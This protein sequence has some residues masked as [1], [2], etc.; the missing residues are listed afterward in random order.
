MAT[1]RFAHLGLA[2]ADLAAARADLERALGVTFEPTEHV[3]SQAVDVAFCDAAGL[4]LVAAT[5][6]RNPAIP[7]LPH[8]IASHLAKHGPGP[9]HVAYAVADLDAAI[10]EARARGV[11]TLTPEPQVGAGGHRVVF[12]HPADCHD[13]LVELCEDPDVR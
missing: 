5:S 13:L 4:E 12:L 9:H 8:P 1:P 10:A 2:V 11:R 3:A 6:D 7:M